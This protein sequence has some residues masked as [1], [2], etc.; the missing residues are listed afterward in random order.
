MR[1]KSVVPAGLD[2]VVSDTV[3]Y[4]VASPTVNNPELNSGRPCGT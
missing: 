4:A 3:G 2:G 1:P